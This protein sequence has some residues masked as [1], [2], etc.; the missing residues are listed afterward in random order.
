MKENDPDAVEIP[1]SSPRYS[2]RSRKP[3]GQPT[4]GK[5]A[6]NRLRRTDIYLA[7]NH[8][9]FLRNL[10]GMY[11]DLGF[12]EE[13]ATTLESASRLRKINPR[14]QFLGVEIDPLRVAS[15]LVFRAPGTDFRLGGFN[16]PLGEDER[17]AVIRAM[18][19]LRQYPESDYLASIAK[20]GSSLMTDGI[21]MEGTCDPQGGKMVFNMYRKQPQGLIFSGLV[22][23]VSHPTSFSPR[24]LQAVLPKNFIHHA[25]PGSPMD[26]FFKDWEACWHQ[27]RGKHPS[28]SSHRF[29]EAGLLL[30]SRYAYAVELRPALLR[31]GFLQLRR[32]PG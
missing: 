21:L 9:G 31:R 25:E 4:R 18:N 13:P 5:T 26:G 24:D 32:I 16:L 7:L 11:V 15:A 20:L 23:S 30:S 12:G 29:E 8:A 19:V 14:I 2:P 6:P 22:F 3:Q 1:I 17:A 28:K 27:A 10:P